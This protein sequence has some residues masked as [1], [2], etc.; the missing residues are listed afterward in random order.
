MLHSQNLQKQPPKLFKPGGARPVRRSWIP[1]NIEEI[2]SRLFKKRVCGGSVGGVFASR[3]ED[4][5]SIPGRDRLSDSSTA[6]SSAM[7]ASVSPSSVMVT[8]QYG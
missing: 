2:I 8:S 4:Q 1:F 5:E 3:A 7:G 6:K